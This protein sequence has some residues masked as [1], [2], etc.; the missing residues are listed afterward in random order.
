MRVKHSAEVVFG[1]KYTASPKQVSGQWVYGHF[2]PV[3]L[4]LGSGD[5]CATIFFDWR[6]NKKL[7]SQKNLSTSFQQV[8]A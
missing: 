1:F 4:W 6:Q 5:I 7:P 2:V 8:L 3:I